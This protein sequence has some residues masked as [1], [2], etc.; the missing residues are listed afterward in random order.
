MF[1]KIQNLHW[2]EVA[3]Q[4]FIIPGAMLM[5]THPD[6]NDAFFS[7]PASRQTS[8]QMAT[9]C[10][11]TTQDVP[12]SSGHT[13]APLTCLAPSQRATTIPHTSHMPSMC[14]SPGH[15]L[16]HV[17]WPPMMHSDVFRHAPP[18]LHCHLLACPSTLSLMGYMP[19]LYHATHAY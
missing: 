17:P 8:P 3:C 7:T 19:T 18:H 16:M 9:S 11:M 15:D 5:C 14:P 10:P 4:L 12:H 1:L 2:V 13:P 6:P